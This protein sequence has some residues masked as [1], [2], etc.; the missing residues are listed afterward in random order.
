MCYHRDAVM[1]VD[2]HLGFGQGIIHVAIFSF[3]R[4]ALRERRIVIPHLMLERFVFHLYALRR[5]D[6]HFL[7]LSRDCRE[8]LAGVVHFLAD[9]GVVL[10]NSLNPGHRRRRTSIDADHFRPRVGRPH[11]L[12]V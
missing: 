8:D 3:V 12:G 6:S 4:V 5:F 1:A 9:E 2:H 7:G 11:Q 10:P